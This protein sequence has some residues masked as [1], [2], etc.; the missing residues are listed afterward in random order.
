MRGG[1]G[2]NSLEVVA[3]D[4]DEEIDIFAES[5]NSTRQVK[6]Q[7]SEREWGSGAPSVVESCDSEEEEQ[8]R[9][10]RRG[11]DLFVAECGCARN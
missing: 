9:M 5:R 4:G 7:T 6:G 1:S 11:F 2:R 8:K 10:E 3:G